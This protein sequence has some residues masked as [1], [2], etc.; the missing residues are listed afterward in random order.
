MRI[1]KAASEF[2]VAGERY[3]TCT[4]YSTDSSLLTYFRPYSIKIPSVAFPEREKNKV[5][6]DARLFLQRGEKNSFSGRRVENFYKVS[7]VNL[8]S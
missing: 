8:S 2:V 6:F 7:Q 5:V 1:V 4:Y 3:I